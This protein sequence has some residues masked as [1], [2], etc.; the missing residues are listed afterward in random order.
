MV[1]IGLEQCFF[2]SRNIGKVTPKMIYLDYLKKYFPDQSIQK[3]FYL[4]LKTAAL[5]WKVERI[6]KKKKL[7]ET[8]DGSLAVLLFSK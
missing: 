5:V 1:G 6:F 2:F 3:T 4:I 8:T 7:D